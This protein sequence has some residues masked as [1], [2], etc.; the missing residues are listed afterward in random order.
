[1]NDALS[2]T[3]DRR[4]VLEG[5]IPASRATQAADAGIRTTEATLRIQADARLDRFSDRGGPK[6]PRKPSPPIT[7]VLR[8]IVIMSNAV[9]GV[10]QCAPEPNAPVRQA[11]RARRARLGGTPKRLRYSSVNVVGLRKP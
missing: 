9:R 6:L 8:I 5:A 3:S 2:P 11:A 1:M 7:V 4:R 10:F